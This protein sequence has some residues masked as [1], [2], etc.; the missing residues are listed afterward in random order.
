MIT[1]YTIG[2]SALKLDE[3]ENYLEAKDYALDTKRTYLYGMRCYWAH[4]FTEVNLQNGLLFRQMLI[5]EGKR[6]KTINILIF[7][8]NVYAKWAGLN[9]YIKDLRV[10]DD[11]FV[12]DGMDLDDYHRLI[13]SLLR[14]GNYKWYVVIKLLAATGMRIG[15]AIQV[16][17]GDLRRGHCSIIGKG[18][19]SREVFFSHILQETLYSYTMHKPDDEKI[20]SCKKNFVRQAF[21]RIKNRYGFKFSLSP[22]DLRRFFARQMFEATGDI[23]LIKGLLGHESVR[24][25][26]LYVRKTHKRALELYSRAQNW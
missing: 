26:S 5:A 1:N 9:I 20:I 21:T 13:D 16:T 12:K 8:L 4:G 18:G 25:T 7:S 3:F 10:N 11:P 23:V 2:T 22:H 6:P 15:E 19:K 24:T 14:D 17:Y